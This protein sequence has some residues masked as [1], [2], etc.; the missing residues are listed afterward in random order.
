MQ[1]SFE[2]YIMGRRIFQRRILR[3]SC[4]PK[5]SEHAS[6]SQSSGRTNASSVGRRQLGSLPCSAAA[7]WL[8]AWA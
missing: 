3:C 4:Q 8:G 5:R 7:P 2:H 6:G 1:A